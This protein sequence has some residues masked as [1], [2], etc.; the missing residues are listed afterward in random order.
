[1]IDPKAMTTLGLLSRA[2]AARRPDAMCHK[3]EGRATTF[4]QFDALA[5]KVANALDAQG[6]K[7]VAYLGKNSDAAYELLVGTARAGG[8]FGPINWRLAPEEVAGVINIFGPDVLCVGPE[9]HAAVEAWKSATTWRM[10]ARAREHQSA[11]AGASR[12]R[13]S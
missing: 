7:L 1:M 6:A 5:D 8:I 9:F 4:A 12:P 11:A 13:V 3:F 10:P 2:N